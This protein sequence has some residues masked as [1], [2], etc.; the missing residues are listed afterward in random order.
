MK[1]METVLWTTLAVGA[2]GVVGCDV[3]LSGRPREDRVFVQQDPQYVQQPAQYVEPQPQYVIVQQAPPAVI[4][5]R[6]PAPPSGAH[7]WID[8]YWHWDS[9]RYTWQTGRYEVPP[10]SNM[11]WVAPRYERDTK[12]YR[13]SPGQW[14]KQNQGNEH[15]NDH[16]NDHTHEKDRN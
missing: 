6:R 12:G 8:G 4:V 7:I 10:Q 13:Y 2:L 3:F 15:G 14:K 16:A 9:Q 1:V 5:E 11:V